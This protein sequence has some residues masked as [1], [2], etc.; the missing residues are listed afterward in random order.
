MSSKRIVLVESSGEIM[1]E[2][3]SVLARP[4]EEEEGRDD[5]ACPPTQRSPQ[6]SGF[7]AAVPRS[8]GQRAA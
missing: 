2:G 8:K 6:D 1:F 4:H 3:V 5:D 7:F